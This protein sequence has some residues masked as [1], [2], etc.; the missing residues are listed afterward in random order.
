MRNKAHQNI[1]WLAGINTSQLLIQLT[2]AEKAEAIL[3]GSQLNKKELVKLAMPMSE[4]CSHLRQSTI[5]Q[6]LEVVRYNNARTM[7]TVAIY[8]IGKVYGQANGEYTK[9]R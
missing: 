6:L 7:D 9:K 2:S 8:E 4:Y 3:I 5:P 1:K